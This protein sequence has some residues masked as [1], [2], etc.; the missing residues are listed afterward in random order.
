MAC[1]RRCAPRGASHRARHHVAD[2]ERLDP[3]GD[4][5]LVGLV[6]GVRRRSR[7]G[8]CRGRGRAGPAGHLH[9]ADVE[10]EAV[11]E[12]DARLAAR[13]ARRRDA[14]PGGGTGS[15]PT[16]EERESDAGSD[17]GGPGGGRRLATVTYA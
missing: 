1:P 2:L 15:L 6:N 3:L 10:P 12:E 13:E 17:R 7:R 4:D 5:D 16:S 8:R 14:C 11:D 9:R